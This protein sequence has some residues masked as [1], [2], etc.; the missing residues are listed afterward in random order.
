M[1]CGKP[2]YATTSTKTDITT[3]TITTTTLH[4]STR[5]RMVVVVRWR[6]VFNGVRG[7]QLSPI[8]NFT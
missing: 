6:D 8:V 7:Q 2:K 1:L 5:R 3:T 4:H